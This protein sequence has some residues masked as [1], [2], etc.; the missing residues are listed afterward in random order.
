[1]KENKMIQKIINEWTYQLDA[2]Y[3]KTDSDYDVLRNVLQELTELDK[4]E[5]HRIVNNARGIREQ[6]N[7]EP[8]STNFTNAEEF[9][10][11]IMAKYAVP[12]QNIKGLSQ[13]YNEVYSIDKKNNNNAL[14]QLISNPP[15]RSITKG[16]YPILGIEAIL[17]DIIDATIKIDNGHESELWFAIVYSGRVAGAVCTSESCIESDIETDNGS[18]SL[19]S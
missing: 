11:F 15:K 6:E 14:H 17:Y 5:I 7:E 13:L 8:T 1:M 3:P 4:P 10:I 19:K 2:G 9:E 12:G 18:V 16:A